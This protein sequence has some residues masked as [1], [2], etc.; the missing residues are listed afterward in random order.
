MQ[1]EGGVDPTRPERNVI[2]TSGTDNLLEHITLGEIIGRIQQI[3]P[4][5]G[6]RNI[7]HGTEYEASRAALQL[8]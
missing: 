2:G 3:Y 5:E 6:S 1:V 7:R 8:N 4:H